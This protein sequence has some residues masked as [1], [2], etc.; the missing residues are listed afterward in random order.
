MCARLRLIYLKKKL[1]GL[2][3][4]VA[5]LDAVIDNPNVA[6]S[7]QANIIAKS[8]NHLKLRSAQFGFI[9]TWSDTTKM[10]YATFNARVETVHQKPVFK[11]AF[12]KR[13]CLVPVAGFYEWRLEKESKQPYLFEANNNDLLYMAGLWSRTLIEDNPIYS[14]TILTTTPVEGY[15]QYHNRMPIILKPDNIDRWVNNDIS[16]ETLSPVDFDYLSV[17]PVNS[18]VN[19]P[20]VKDLELIDQ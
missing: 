4:L 11:D 7:E 1:E 10:K 3:T 19:N 6:P 14:F 18:A 8:D 16:T 9:P 2:S 13:H 5:N 12:T 15:E 20:S 17:K